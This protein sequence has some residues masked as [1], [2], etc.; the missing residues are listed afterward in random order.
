MIYYKYSC[1]GKH[2]FPFF[3]NSRGHAELIRS[4]RGGTVSCQVSYGG[5]QL[6]GS[7][8]L[9][10]KPEAVETMKTDPIL[11][12]IS[13]SWAAEAVWTQKLYRILGKFYN[14][15]PI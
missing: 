15:L 7:K 4:T 14:W 3:F 6:W 1:E 2:F 11:G 8:P 13:Y 12:K 9:P 5:V 10:Y